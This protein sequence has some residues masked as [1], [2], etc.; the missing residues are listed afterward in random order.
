MRE[1]TYE[2]AFGM[3]IV[4]RHAVMH[5]IVFCCLLSWRGWNRPGCFARLTG[6]WAVWRMGFV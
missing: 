4:I 5:L 1:I 2:I 6:A 3:K